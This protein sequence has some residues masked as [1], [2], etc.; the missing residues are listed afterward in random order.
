MLTGYVITCGNTKSFIT[1]TYKV[2]SQ[3]FSNFIGNILQKMKQE[4][5]LLVKRYLLYTE[6][7]S[8]KIM[9]MTL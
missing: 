3:I 4:K 1:Q 7:K 9:C 8:L 5:L 6:L 2:K